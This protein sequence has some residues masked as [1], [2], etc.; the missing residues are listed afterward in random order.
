MTDNLLTKEQI[1]QGADATYDIHVKALGGTVRVRHV[2]DGEMA[3]W[4]AR[5][6]R[7]QRI[8]Q[9]M[10]QGSS[11]NGDGSEQAN[12]DIGTGTIDIDLH[13]SHSAIQDSNCWL[14]AK[15]L[16]H[17]GEKWS[18]QEVKKMP[19]GAPG[20]IATAIRDHYRQAEEGAGDAS[21]SFPG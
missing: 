2:T 9:S 21:K 19:P 18:E 7:G 15:A 14:V 20:E 16:S 5:R 10:E 6:V 12:P 8:R 11:E 13:A 17:S 1:L 3:E 4:Q